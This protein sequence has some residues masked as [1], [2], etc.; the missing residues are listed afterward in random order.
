M[1]VVT[2]VLLPHGEFANGSISQSN[3]VSIKVFLSPEHI[4]N[5][6]MSEAVSNSG[7]GGRVE[8][9]VLDGNF[10]LAAIDSCEGPGFVENPL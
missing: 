8:R 4:I 10:S 2:G 6:Y 1:Q 9:I 7:V 5:G 3:E